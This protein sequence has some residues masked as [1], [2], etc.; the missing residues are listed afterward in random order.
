VKFLTVG[1]ASGIELETT[2][3]VTVQTVLYLCAKFKTFLQAILWVCHRLQERKKQQKYSCKQQLQGQ[4][5]KQ[6]TRHAII[7]TPMITIGASSPSVL[8][9]Q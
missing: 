1:G 9:P 5:Q 7:R 3:M 8:D 2:A 6:M 4:A